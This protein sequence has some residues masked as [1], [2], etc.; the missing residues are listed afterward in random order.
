MVQKWFQSGIM[1]CRIERLPHTYGYGCWTIR[2][3][4]NATTS[5]QP[6]DRATPLQTTYPIADPIDL[7]KRAG[8]GGRWRYAQSAQRGVTHTLFEM[9]PMSIALGVAPYK[10]V[11]AER[12]AILRRWSRFIQRLGRDIAWTQRLGDRL[13]SAD[14]ARGRLTHLSSQRLSSTLRGTFSHKGGR[15]RRICI[16]DNRSAGDM[17]DALKAKRACGA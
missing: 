5:A 1:N 16:H 4:N 15:K 17:K 14:A 10:V 12:S 3:G 2:H 13:E 7:A 9:H 6:G 8:S 11:S